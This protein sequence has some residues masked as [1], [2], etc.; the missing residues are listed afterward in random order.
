MSQVLR[1]LRRVRP[2]SGLSAF[3]GLS[4]WSSCQAP[5]F[6]FPSALLGGVGG[7]LKVLAAVL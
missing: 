5:H 4:G 7:G 2:P 1:V 3:E 6:P